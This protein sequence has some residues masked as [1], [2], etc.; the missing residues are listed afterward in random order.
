MIYMSKVLEPIGESKS[1]FEIFSG[2]A[3]K[4]NL[5]DDYTEKKSEKEWIEWIYNE[6]NDLQETNH[7]FPDFDN[8]K[9]RDGT[10]SPDQLINK[11]F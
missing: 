8:F 7:K 5:K 6:S 3:K 2:L 4:F 9:K 1:D 11:Y 10:N